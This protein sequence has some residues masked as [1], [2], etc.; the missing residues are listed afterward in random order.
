MHSSFRSAFFI[1]S[2]LLFPADSKPT[3]FCKPIPGDHDWPS[4]KA[5]ANL[6]TTVSGRLLRPIPPGAVCHEDQSFIPYDVVKCSQVQAGWTDWNFHTVDLVSTGKTNWSNDTCLPFTGFSC[7]TIDYP[8]YVIN[9]TSTPDVQAGVLFGESTR[10][11]PP[12]FQAPTCPPP[13]LLFGTRLTLR[14]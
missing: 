6:N 2:L 5:W 14:P 3:P 10:T 8:T 9:A 12:H 11:R 13:H 4:V 1:I 7:D